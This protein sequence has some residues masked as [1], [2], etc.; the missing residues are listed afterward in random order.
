MD[1]KKIERYLKDDYKSIE[2]LL[3][4]AGFANLTMNNNEIRCGWD[5]TTN[6]DSVAVDIDTLQSSDY[7]RSIFGNIYTLLQARLDLDFIGVLKWIQGKLNLNQEDFKRREV[8]LPFGGFFKDISMDNAKR[9]EDE[10]VEVYSDVLLNRYGCRPCQR[11][12][13]DG[14]SAKTQDIYHVGFDVNSGRITIPWRN[15]DGEV[16]GVMGRINEDVGEGEQEYYGA[17]WMPVVPFQKSKVV[18]GVYE[19]KSHIQNKDI[20]IVFES[21]KSPMLLND[22]GNPVGVA[23]GGSNISED[24]ANIIKSLN[25]SII[26]TAYDE[27]VEEAEIIKNTAKLKSSTLFGSNRVGYIYDENNKYLEKGKKQAPCDLG[28]DVLQGLITECVKWL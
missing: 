22:Y 15:E 11:F 12:I 28:K 5:E 20:V 3:L 18:F 6:P 2:V 19:N 4:G 17:K 9:V 10:P 16:V 7:G 27:G 24:K 8:V 14:I 21:E 23:L 26:I 13:D 25:T 1:A